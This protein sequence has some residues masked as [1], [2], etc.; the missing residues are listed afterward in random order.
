MLRP[1][2]TLGRR[3]DGAFCLSLWY[4]ASCAASATA[5]DASPASKLRPRGPPPPPPGA[6][7][8]VSSSGV[9]FARRLRQNREMSAHVG[10]RV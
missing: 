8:S 2:S 10:F 6:M 7:R 4:F 9:A 1:T 5:D 3:V